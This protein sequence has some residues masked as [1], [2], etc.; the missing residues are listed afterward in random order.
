[1]HNAIPIDVICMHSK[2]GKMVPLRIRVTD[3]E[4][5][6]QSFTIKEYRELSHQGTYTRP[7]GVYVTGET[8]IFTS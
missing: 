7:D 1:M 4:G 3:E 6:N 8:L 5:L 2:D